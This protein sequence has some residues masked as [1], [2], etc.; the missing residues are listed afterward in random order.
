[1]IGFPTL[2]IHSGMIGG[3]PVF[4]QAIHFRHAANRLISGLPDSLQRPLDICMHMV[5]EREIPGGKDRYIDKQIDGG[6]DNTFAFHAQH[7]V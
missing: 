6:R 4:S 5:R 7:S 1:M 3:H 2:S